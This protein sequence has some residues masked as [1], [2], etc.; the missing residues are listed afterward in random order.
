MVGNSPS[1]PG[2]TVV[3]TVL[4]PVDLTFQDNRSSLSPQLDGSVNV[5]AI[6]HSPVFQDATFAATG[7]TTGHPRSARGVSRG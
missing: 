1:H 3:P 7:D 6:L 5:P 4:V 2:T